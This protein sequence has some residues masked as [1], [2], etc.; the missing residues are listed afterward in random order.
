[1][2]MRLRYIH[3]LLERG[4]RVPRRKKR[5]KVRIIS[6]SRIEFLIIMSTELS[7]QQYEAGF[8]ALQKGKGKE[9]DSK[10]K[11]R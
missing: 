3:V 1:M 9:I 10:P 7:K 4:S 6:R 5:H 2:I 11:V 8:K